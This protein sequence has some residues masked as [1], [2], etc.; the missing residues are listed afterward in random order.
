MV[1]DAAILAVI[2]SPEHILR[3]HHCFSEEILT[4]DHFNVLRKNLDIIIERRNG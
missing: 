4:V 3:R 2:N 1:I